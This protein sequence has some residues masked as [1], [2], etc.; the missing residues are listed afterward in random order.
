MKISSHLLDANEDTRGDGLPSDG[1]LVREDVGGL[2]M[3]Y[4]ICT[5]RFDSI[6][7]DWGGSAPKSNNENKRHDKGAHSDHRNPN[8]FRNAASLT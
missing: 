6:D 1:W 2:G 5:D 3:D 7:S 4:A 8:G